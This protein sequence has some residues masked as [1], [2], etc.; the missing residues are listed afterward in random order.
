MSDHVEHSA[1]C[2]AVADELAEL[3]LGTLSGRR[4][5][6]VLDHVGSC[7]HCR[8]ELEQLAVV[9]EALQQLAPQV[10][11]PLGFESRLAQ[12]LRG[13]ATPRSRRSRR[14]GALSAAAAVVMLAF[15]LG[16]LV[17]RGAGNGGGQPATA[18]LVTANFTSGGRVVGAVMI[19]PGSP[20]WMLVTIT[21]GGWH[22]TVTCDVTLAGGQVETIGAFR[23]SGEYSAWAAP[24]TSTV[25][26]VRSARLIDSNG[27]ILAT[28]RVGA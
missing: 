19:S 9:I 11:P 5:S 15:G 22:G 17:A 3:A 10:Q 25:G 6:E 26:Q 7:A 4:R 1:Q 21:G 28:A 8:A 13:T 20:A 18:N 24:L 27:A 14:V 16:V 12:R 2:E 23:L